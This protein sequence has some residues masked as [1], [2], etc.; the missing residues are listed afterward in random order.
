MSRDGWGFW[1]ALLYPVFWAVIFLVLSYIV[2]EWM[3]PDLEWKIYVV[4]TL[5]GLI[6]GLG[7]VLLS[8]TL[9]RR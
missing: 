3:F 2:V 5:V 9:L 1:N 8:R 6:A 7:S 4:M